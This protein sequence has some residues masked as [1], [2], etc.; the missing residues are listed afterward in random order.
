VDYFFFKFI[1]K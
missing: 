1:D